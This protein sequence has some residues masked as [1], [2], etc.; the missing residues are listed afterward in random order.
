MPYVPLKA[1]SFLSNG[2][3]IVTPD[4]VRYQ[5]NRSETTFIYSASH[6]H[7]F[8]YTSAYYVGAII[9]P[10]N[11][12][13]IA[14]DY[15]SAGY[16]NTWHT[17]D[18]EGTE[19][20]CMIPL[21]GS[22]VYAEHITTRP[23]PTR[24]AKAYMT[25]VPTV[26]PYHIS[27]NEGRLTFNLSGRSDVA[28]GQ[29][30][31]DNIVVERSD[32]EG[33]EP[34]RRINFH[35]SYF[36]TTSAD[37][38][39]QRLCLDSVTV[40]GYDNGAECGTEL[41]SSFEYY[42]NK[43]L[44]S[45][46]N[47]SVDYWGYYN[48]RA[49]GSLIPRTF[50]G[51]RLVAGMAD[52]RPD[53]TY[54]QYGT[55]KSVGYSTGGRTEFTW[56]INR[57]GSELYANSNKGQSENGGVRTVRLSAFV[58][59]DSAVT[60]MRNK[61]SISC[62]DCFQVTPDTRQKITITYCMSQKADTHDGQYML[63]RKYDKCVIYQ[64]DTPIKTVM[65]SSTRM[66]GT[67]D[68]WLEA[69][70]AYIFKIGSNCRNL[71]GSMSASLNMNGGTTA[72]TAATSD[73]AFTG[74]RIK[75]ITQYDYDGTELS[76]KEYGYTDS[77]GNS[78]GYITTTAGISNSKVETSI[79]ETN[80][81]L[82][83]T[84]RRLVYSDLKSGPYEN[85]YAYRL[86]TE[87]LFD[88]GSDTPVRQ[89]VYEFPK[90]M[91]EYVAYGIPA[92]DMSHLR[93]GCVRMSEY[94]CA[95]GGG[96]TIKRVT[97]NHYSRDQRICYSRTGF[98]MNTDFIPDP[99]GS[100]TAFGK[101]LQVLGYNV[102][103]VYVPDNFTYHCDWLH[104]DS[105]TVTE[106]FACGSTS[107]TQTF[108]EY[109]SR[110]HL[111]PTMETATLG[112]IS[113][114]THTS[115][116][117][118]CDGDIYE[119][120]ED[121]NML[122]N[123]VDVR[124]Y[125]GD[126]NGSVT[127]RGGQ[128]KEYAVDQYDH[129]VLSGTS[130]Y[131]HDG[132]LRTLYTYKYDGNGRLVECTGPDSVATM[133]LWNGTGSCP[134][135]VARGKSYSP[136]LS[137]ISASKSPLTL[138]KLQG[139]SKSIVMAYTYL[140][141]TGITS[142]TQPNGLT[143]TYSYDGMG[144]LRCVYGA[145]GKQVRQYGYF[146]P[147]RTVET[148]LNDTIGD[149]SSSN[150]QYYDGIG[151]PVLSAS[152]GV[153]T[154]G[155]YVYGFSEYDASGNVSRQWLPVAGGTDPSHLSASDIA[156]MSSAFYGD[157]HPFSDITYDGL[158]R[159]VF[160]SAAGDAWNS[161]VRGDS[162]TYITNAA[163]SVK[164]YVP[165][166]SADGFHQDGFF[167]AGSLR[168][169]RV[170]DADGRSME[171][172]CD[173]H[174]NTVL[175]RRGNSN[176]TYYVY[177][178]CGQLSAVLPPM[179][180]TDPENK[181]LYTYRYAY[182]NRG[183]CVE[184]TLPGC[185]TTQYWYDRAG[186]LAYMQDGRMRDRSVYRFYMYDHLGRPAVRGICSGFT[187]QP[188]SML[189]TVRFGSGNSEVLGTR[190]YITGDSPLTG[191]TL[192]E[193]Q[194]YDSY[195]GNLGTLLKSANTP[196]GI[197]A[198]SNGCSTR[199]LPTIRVTATGNGE[200]LV[201]V[202]HYD[203]Y[204]RV[205]DV[206]SVYPSGFYRK[207]VTRYSFTDKPVSVKA[208]YSR[209]GYSLPF[210]K[211]THTYDYNQNSGLLAEECIGFRDR[212]PY[213]VR[214]LGYDGLGRTASCKYGTA[215]TEVVAG[216]F[217]YDLHGWPVSSEFTNTLGNGSVIFGETLHYADGPGTP[218]YNGNISSDNWRCAYSG[219]TIHSMKYT[220]DSLDRLSRTMYG[221]GQNWFYDRYSEIFTY[222]ANCS[223]A[224]VMR[225]GK[226][227]TGYG[228]IDLLSYS[229]TGNRLKSVDDAVSGR[230]MAYSGAF[231]FKDGAHEEDEYAYD[232]CGALTQDRNKGI[233]MVDYDYGGNPVRVQFRNGNV[234]EYVYSSRGT[235]LRTIHRKA[236]PGLM[237]PFG[238]RHTLTSA[239]TLSVDSTTHIGNL[240]IDMYTNCKYYFDGG[241]L[242]LGNTASGTYHFM[243]SDRQG[244]VRAVV[245]EDGSLEQEDN[246]FAYGGLLNDVTT[247][248]DLQTHKYGGKELDRMHGLD[249]YD[250]GARWYDS[251]LGL[252]TS[253]DPMCEKY[254]NLN[255]YLYCSGNPIKYVDPNG[256]TIKVVDK[257][258][259]FLFA[260]D[261]GMKKNTSM[262]SKQLYDK[263]I[264][265]FAP[266]ADNYMQLLYKNKNIS[267]KDGIKH[268]SWDDIVQFAEVDRPSLSYRNHGS[269]DWKKS[270]N[271]GDG[272]ILVT[273]DGMPYWADAIGQIPFALDTYRKCLKLFLSHSAA[274]CVTH[275]LGQK[276]S[277]GNIVNDLRKSP[278]ISNSYDNEMIMRAIRWAKH[279]YIIV[280]NKSWY[281]RKTIK[282]TDYSP[283]F[284]AKPLL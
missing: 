27:F 91:D 88:G 212:T 72:N 37:T 170:R 51:S 277:T 62:F 257:K 128:H 117:S 180:Q 197:Y 87:S 75:K 34:V 207:T 4:G 274:A 262:T 29:K 132:S 178:N 165:D 113:S 229:Y 279:R 230:Y 97:R 151:R 205:C 122:W 92:I 200:K 196:Y 224:S 237:V 228:V 1:H 126:H 283:K 103:D 21:T 166:A 79:R 153:N 227:S 64:N 74:L 112:D 213:K 55:I 129:V 255:P 193:A 169:T 269:G 220:Y 248:V 225:A 249:L 145:H 177:D 60:C 26:V 143:T 83:V 185:A 121:R 35:Y 84:K 219:D 263:G 70:S 271:P 135:A 17:F 77:V 156:S 116:P 10:N 232:S 46:T 25:H 69:D 71:T 115:Y 155:T 52:R 142:I 44:P 39:V 173:I 186:R 243:V 198:G 235:K 59:P 152:N 54:L 93:S 238:E 120:M 270:G 256:D 275:E 164:R 86:V 19:T 11:T 175:E 209:D 61:L 131:N 31:L 260:L 109:G 215:D 284:L 136:S 176:D 203:S 14:Y 3:E 204:G 82:M 66:E 133:V 211:I 187:V 23:V 250:F 280:G 107:V 41:V 43:R 191:E 13:T 247:G 261:D 125:T 265:W 217:D 102:S 45:K 252:F 272:Y 150:I 182:D 199:S 206:R 12:D 96:M 100:S 67:V 214:A 101:W 158:Q 174:G 36:N 192:E 172:Y 49:N 63:H 18:Y 48:G 94:E 5:F 242:S 194:Y 282:T 161:P 190:Y 124:M 201:D 40:T 114:I 76:R 85:D 163:S 216:T 226:T 99:N 168:G 57:T 8:P 140:P 240:D 157:G 147:D 65:M 24:T 251:N 254:Y 208:E 221:M 42:G 259:D 146:L 56:E 98:V 264:Q 234:T 15:Q 130:A 210:N 110:K 276:F 89:T 179:C 16:C 273:V 266:T 6:V 58:E 181:G 267:N 222:N 28:G 233:C 9:S 231:D 218:C 159:P 33:Y 162:T 281:K 68:V 20:T 106:Y 278:D 223:P 119:G 80:A 141:L 253:M 138:Y 22:S 241:Y 236:M 38:L 154:D 30:K 144:R 137:T 189:M 7:K 202:M 127:L 123:P 258:N 139:F 245:G 148:V 184:R 50:D 118:D 47:R 90:V 78:T 246:Y 105:T 53:G 32:G 239:E 111:Q 149:G 104:L 73:Y 95:D 268:F 81:N 195:N 160:M 167:P 188:Q 183:L 244:N 2:G 108:Y 134:V 171:V